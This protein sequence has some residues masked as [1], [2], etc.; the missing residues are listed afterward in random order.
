MSTTIGWIFLMPVMSMILSQ[1]CNP[2]VVAFKR[3]SSGASPS[4]TIFWQS[5][6]KPCSLAYSRARTWSDLWVIRRALRRSLR[7]MALRTS[8]ADSPSSEAISERGFCW[9]LKESASSSS[10]PRVILL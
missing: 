6:T 4:V 7:V 1:T 3:S 10:S 2:T 9:R 5:A 8:C